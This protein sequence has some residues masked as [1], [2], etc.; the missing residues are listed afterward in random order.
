MLMYLLAFAG[1]M[2]GFSKKEKFKIAGSLFSGLGLIFV[3]LEVMS[4]EQ[5]FG[6]QLVKD[7]F[8]RIFETI[9]FPLLL[10]LV[11]IIFTALI[12]SS[13]AATGVVRRKRNSLDR[14][15]VTPAPFSRDAMANFMC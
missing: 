4:G 9:D 8:T 11:G 10:I 13:S 6:N 3:G 1:V 2:M 15:T 5:A 7:M 14:V 12:Q